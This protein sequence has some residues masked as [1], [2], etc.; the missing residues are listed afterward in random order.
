[1]T[2]THASPFVLLALACSPAFAAMP[3][4]PPAGPTVD[5]VGVWK[6]MV[7][8]TVCATGLPVPG[9]VPFPALNSFFMDG[10]VIENGAGLSSAKRSISHGRWQQVGKRTFIARSELQLFENADLSWSGWQV[11]ERTLHVAADGNTLT[12]VATFMR[13]DTEGTLTFQGCATEE[14]T[15]QPEPAPAT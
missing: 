7:Q 3:A 12:S 6:N 15:R 13:Y 2:R 14:G 4:E 11:M 8:F 10:N 1:M 9:R 5:I